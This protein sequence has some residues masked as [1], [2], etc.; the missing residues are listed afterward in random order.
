M[1]V[2]LSIDTKDIEKKLK[3]L[4][5]FPKH[6]RK[7]ANSAI[8]RTLT[9]TNKR[10]NQEIRKSYNIKTAE[11]K[12]TIT[13]KKSNPNTLRGEI[14][15]SDRRLSLGRFQRGK[16]K[17]GKP[18][19]VKVTKTVKTVNTNPKA[20]VISLNGNNHVAKRTGKKSYPIEVLRTLSVPQM[21]T[22]KRVEPTVSKESQEYLLKRTNHEIEYQMKKI[23]GGR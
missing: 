22:S 3:K 23:I 20:F 21:I 11:I 12:G 5:L 1:A 16:F 8:N 15:S 4:K 14:N 19:K 17:R 9:F 13:I 6:A 2:S 7:A 18:V 10:I